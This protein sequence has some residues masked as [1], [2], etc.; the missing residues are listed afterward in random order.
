MD[1]IDEIN[2]QPYVDAIKMKKLSWNIFVKV[3]KDFFYSDINRLKHINAI[4]LIELTISYSDMDRLK[5]LNEILLKSPNEFGLKTAFKKLRCYG[6]MQ[7][8]PKKFQNLKNSSK[9]SI[10]NK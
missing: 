1:N 4:L 5:Y 9:I 6:N 3:M 8:C 2:F 10:R 7:K